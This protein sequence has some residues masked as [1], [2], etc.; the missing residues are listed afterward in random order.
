MA[1]WQSIRHGLMAL[2]ANQTDVS[3][4]RQTFGGPARRRGRAEFNLR[5]Q[6]I[7]EK[8]N[9]GGGKKERKK[10][11]TEGNFRVSSADWLLCH[12]SPLLFLLLLHLLL[13]VAK[14]C[15]SNANRLLVFAKQ[16]ATRRVNTAHVYTF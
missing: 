15:L 5:Q 10:E 2:S 4:Q 16:S 1:A 8:R 3:L 7:R 11:M 13:L 14:V 12:S 9:G 6:S